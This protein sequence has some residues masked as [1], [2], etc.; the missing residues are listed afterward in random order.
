MRKLLANLAMGSAAYGLWALCANGCAPAVIVSAGLTAGFGL[1]QTQA[2]QFI[3]G[4]LKA[5][6]QTSLD[7]ALNATRNVMQ[8]LQLPIKADRRS[9]RKAYLNGEAEGGPQVGVTLTSICPVATKIEIRVGILGDQA[10]SRLV[11]ERIDAQLGPPAS[12]QPAS[13][14]TH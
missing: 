12:S 3:N 2:A 14:T 11:M 6:R 8:E 7:Q 9:S 13:L 4:E 10:V 1:A 5:A